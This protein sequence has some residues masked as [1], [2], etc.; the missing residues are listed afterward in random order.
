MCARPRHKMRVRVNGSSGRQL[1]PAYMRVTLD[2]P[3]ST[4]S[5]SF[6]KI[7]YFSIQIYT[8]CYKKS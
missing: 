2:A 1:L 4:S 3:Y 6:H 8:A 7:F 5:F